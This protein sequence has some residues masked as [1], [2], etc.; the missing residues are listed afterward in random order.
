MTLDDSHLHPGAGQPECQRRSGL[1]GTD[2]D[3]VKVGHEAL[4]QQEACL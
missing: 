2:D 1:A 4:R 3:R